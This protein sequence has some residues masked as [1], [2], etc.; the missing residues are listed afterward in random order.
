MEVNFVWICGVNGLLVVVSEL[1]VRAKTALLSLKCT[2]LE[3]GDPSLRPNI[4]FMYL[5]MRLDMQTIRFETHAIAG[6]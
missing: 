5:K 1:E 4:I 2:I 3:D 6:R